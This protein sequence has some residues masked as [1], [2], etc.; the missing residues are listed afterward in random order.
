MDKYELKLIKLYL[1]AETDIINEIA[2][3]RSLGLADYHAVATLQRVQKILYAMRSDAWEYVP[4][5]E[6]S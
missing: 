3:L 2:R 1:Q 5:R 4:I 6:N